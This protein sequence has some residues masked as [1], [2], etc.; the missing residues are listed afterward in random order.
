VC[1]RLLLFAG[2]GFSDYF[3]LVLVSH[4]SIEPTHQNFTW[5][6]DLSL[7]QTTSTSLQDYLSVSLTVIVSPQLGLH[8]VSNPSLIVLELCR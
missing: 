6:A 2:L 5:L 1:Y 3:T 7:P 8:D 4:F